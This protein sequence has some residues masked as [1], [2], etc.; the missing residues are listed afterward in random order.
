VKSVK[1]K[2]KFCHDSFVYS[3]G[4]RKTANRVVVRSTY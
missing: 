3:S 1:S 4:K 2:Q